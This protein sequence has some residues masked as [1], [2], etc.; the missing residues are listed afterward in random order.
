MENRI[1]SS[2]T[3]ISAKQSAPAQS[4][5]AT[6]ASAPAEVS[7]AETTTAAT[8]T[9]INDLEA[10][11]CPREPT[12][13]NNR[14]LRD[15]P[16]PRAGEVGVY[17]RTFHHGET[18][19]AVFAGDD[20]GFSTDRDVTARIR[21]GAVLQPQ[22]DG[23]LDLQ[24]FGGRSDQTTFLPT[25]TTETEV[26]EVTAHIIDNDRGFTD[27]TL[28]YSGA[29]PLVA[30]APEV[31]SH[32]TFSLRDQDGVLSVRAQVSADDFPNAE[33]FL[34]DG[35]GNAVFVGVHTPDRND[36]VESLI[37]GADTELI[38]VSFEV[39][40]D[41]CGNFTGVMQ[42]GEVFTIEQWNAQFE[43]RSASLWGSNPEAQDARQLAMMRQRL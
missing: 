6:A 35:A 16:L 34:R 7:E 24:R 1:P 26:P 21:A 15:A 12:R 23:T 9:A 22:G 14:P 41:E 13:A 38:D 18:L 40:H 19:G 8:E 4:E 31:N 5:A 32:S 20:R 39:L 30:I 10:C 11:H 2:P 43:E 3:H 17:V 36:N 28:D 42:Q 37:G 25:G 33:A 27:L 29:D